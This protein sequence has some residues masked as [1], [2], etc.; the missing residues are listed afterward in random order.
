M[1]LQPLTAVIACI[2]VPIAFCL[3]FYCYPALLRDSRND[4]RVVAFRSASTIASCTMCILIVQLSPAGC[5]LE[6]SAWLGLRLTPRAVLLPAVVSLSMYTGPLLQIIQGRSPV[7]YC[8]AD[9][10]IKFRNL[11]IAPLVEEL[12][13]RGC[14]VRILAS[15]QFHPATI[16]LVAPLFFGLAHLHHILENVWIRGL[17]PRKATFEQLLQFSHTT[18]FGIIATL[19]FTSAG[20]VAAPTLLHV[21]CNWMGLPVI[22]RGK[23]TKSIAIVWGTMAVVGL[24]VLVR[25]IQPLALP[26][27]CPR[28]S[29]LATR[30]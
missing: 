1:S 26:L 19:V 20:S 27:G 7:P 9:L 23:H 21:G 10:H 11:L 29:G 24:A 28:T 16:T 12:L 13:F 30:T 3:P 5:N 18:A 22:V 14:I 25:N 4:I 8:K 6:L 17:P 15:A 2:L